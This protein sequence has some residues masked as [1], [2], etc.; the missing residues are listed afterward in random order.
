[1]DKLGSHISIITIFLDL[2]LFSFIYNYYLETIDRLYY[3]DSENV[4]K[5]SD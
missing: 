3:H 4:M 2:L 5:C 1:M